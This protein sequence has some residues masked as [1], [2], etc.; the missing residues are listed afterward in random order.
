VCG[1]DAL[2]EAY[3]TAWAEAFAVK[4]DVVPA[5]WRMSKLLDVGWAVVHIDVDG[6]A[7]TVGGRLVEN[8]R[9]SR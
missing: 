2:V 6:F 8:G 4:A 5:E 9:W 3:V 1:T 7:F